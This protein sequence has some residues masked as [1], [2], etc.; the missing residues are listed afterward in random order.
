VMAKPK[1]IVIDK[2]AFQ[3]IKLDSLCK[4]VKHHLLLVSDSLLYECATAEKNKRQDPADLVAR[5]E[6]LILLFNVAQIC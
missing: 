5:Y 6:C 1:Q 3:G 4:F 2:S